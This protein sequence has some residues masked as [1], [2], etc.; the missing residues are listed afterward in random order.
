MI[1]RKERLL[2][3]IQSCSVKIVNRTMA[4]VKPCNPSNQFLMAGLISLRSAAGQSQNRNQAHIYKL[5]IKALQKYPLPVIHPEQALDLQGLGPSS[6]GSLH[7]IFRKSGVFYK[8]LKKESISTVPEEVEMKVKLFV[9][10]RET[11]GNELVSLLEKAGIPVVVK[12]LPLGDFLFVVEKGEKCF[13]FDLIVERKSASD[14]NSSNFSNHLQD[15]IR[16]LKNS[17]FQSKILLVEGKSNFKIISQVCLRFSVKVVL[18][19]NQTRMIDFFKQ[20]YEFFVL[21]VKNCQQVEKLRSFDEFLKKENLDENVGQIFYRQILEFPGIT[22]KKLNFF[23]SL[24]PTMIDF[25]KAYQEDKALVRQNLAW[26]G[27][28]NALE[29]CIFDFFGMRR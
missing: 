2:K 26:C 11:R 18:V 7:K 5:S 1:N 14:L 27:I 16:R 12:T 4:T 20:F 19:L 21:T 3:V 10:Q 8:N 29:S 22:S 25:L 17:N 13:V 15:Q 23:V 6:L 24:Y 28:G 9:D